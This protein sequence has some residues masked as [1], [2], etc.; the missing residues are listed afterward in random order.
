MEE[1]ADSWDEFEAPGRDIADESKEKRKASLDIPR[2]KIVVQV[3]IGQ[4]KDQGVKIASR[5]LWDPATDNYVA[6]SFQNQHSWACATV[7]GLYT[8]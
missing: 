7:F 6:V 8:D 5:C 3:T 1:R 4:M 2:H